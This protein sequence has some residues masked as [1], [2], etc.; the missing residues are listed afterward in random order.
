MRRVQTDSMSKSIEGKIHREESR[1]CTLYDG[2][3]GGTGME[4]GEKSAR[5]LS[6]GTV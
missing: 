2:E 4:S 6:N 3:L 1:C 5:R